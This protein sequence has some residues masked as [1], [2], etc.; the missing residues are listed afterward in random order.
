M[1]DANERARL[2]AD[3]EDFIKFLSDIMLDK[4]PED[5]AVIDSLAKLMHSPYSAFDDVVSALNA[6]MASV[7]NDPNYAD[8]M[9]DKKV[10][11]DKM[12]ANLIEHVEGNE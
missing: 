1:M 9:H 3:R 5:R 8:A 7:I 2:I 4:T 11:W 10:E 12:H 6:N